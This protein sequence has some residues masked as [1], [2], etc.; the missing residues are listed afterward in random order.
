MVNIINN[1]NIYRIKN[2]KNNINDTAD[3]DFH[4]P[5]YIFLVAFKQNLGAPCNACRAHIHKFQHSTLFLL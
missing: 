2:E 1:P 4:F 5:F 3:Q